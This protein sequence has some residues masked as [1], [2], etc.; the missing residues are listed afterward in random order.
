MCEMFLYSYIEINYIHYTNY[1]K[2]NVRKGT[3]YERRQIWTIIIYGDYGGERS[4]TVW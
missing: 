1:T 2:T 3:H 4:G